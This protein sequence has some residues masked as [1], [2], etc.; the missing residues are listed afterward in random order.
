M[1]F[2]RQSFTLIELLVVVAIIAILAA[3]LLPA[4]SQARE[5]AKQAACMNNLKQCGI[6][7]HLYA[8][9]NAGWMMPNGGALYWTTSGYLNRSWDYSMRTLGYITATNSFICP[10]Q[11]KELNVYSE[12]WCYGGFLNDA[13]CVSAMMK[14]YGSYGNASANWTTVTP[15]RMILL[16]DSVRGSGTLYD[17]RQFFAAWCDD[18]SRAVHCRHSRRANALL[19]D[20]HVE[21]LSKA[22][23]ISASGGQ[24]KYGGNWAP[25]YPNNVVEQ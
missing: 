8:D 1:R 17:G 20:G 7:Y 5:K 18:P 24:Y 10:S 13:C 16:I 15:Q 12:G 3:L 11:L 4:L 21:A 9:D 25:A 23:L 22:E 14:L 19:A 2:N 6:G